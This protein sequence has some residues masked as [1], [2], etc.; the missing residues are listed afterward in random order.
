MATTA[1]TATTATGTIRATPIAIATTANKRDAS[2][3]GRGRERTADR[4]GEPPS[5]DRQ[6][7]SAKRPDEIVGSDVK[8]ELSQLYPSG[9]QWHCSFSFAEETCR[10]A[11]PHHSG[12][13]H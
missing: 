7:L 13:E 3:A 9:G 2:L 12:R 10:R 8:R 1:A 6:F 4:A 11:Q 5:V